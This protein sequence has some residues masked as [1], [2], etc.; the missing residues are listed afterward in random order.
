[1]SAVKNPVGT[2]RDVVLRMAVDQALDPTVNI[3]FI[4]SSRSAE[5]FNVCFVQKGGAGAPASSEGTALKQRMVEKETISSV[6]FGGPEYGTGDTFYDPLHHLI[7][8][9]DSQLR[10]APRQG[11]RQTYDPSADTSLENKPGTSKTFKSNF[12]DE[13]DV[14]VHTRNISERSASGFGGGS[15]FDMDGLSFGLEV[16][17]DHLQQRLKQSGAGKVRVQLIPSCGMSIKDPS[18]HML[19]NGFIF[20]VDGSDVISEAQ[21]ANGAGIPATE[22]AFV[23]TVGEYSQLFEAAGKIMVHNPEDLV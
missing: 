3:K 22:N 19:P 13:R 23:S 10:A 17:L 12:G 1:V 5:I 4:T 21:K 9:Y 18:K 2:K 14:N 11:A 15:L 6:D 7:N 8:F 16:C 20:N